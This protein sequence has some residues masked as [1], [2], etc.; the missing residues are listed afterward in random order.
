VLGN[1]SRL[2]G[3]FGLK[4]TTNNFYSAK[5]TVIQELNKGMKKQFDRPDI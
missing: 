4:I 3:L 5:P 1:F 2:L